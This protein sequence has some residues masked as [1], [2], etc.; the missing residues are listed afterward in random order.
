MC[1]LDQ[2]GKLGS[3]RE[4]EAFPVKGVTLSLT[5]TCFLVDVHVTSCHGDVTSGTDLEDPDDLTQFPKGSVT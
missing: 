5:M 4:N 3:G 1:F 2:G